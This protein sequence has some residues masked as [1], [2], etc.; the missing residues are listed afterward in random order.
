MRIK[1]HH[2]GWINDI[3]LNFKFLIIYVV[4]LLIPIFAINA[5]FFYRFAG[6][7]DE[8]EQ[9][10]YQI[11]LERARTDIESVLE[12]CIAVSHSISTDSVLYNLLDITYESKEAYFESYNTVLRNRVTTY[13]DVYDYISGLKLYVNNPT[14]SNGGSYYCI[15]DDIKHSAWYGAIQSSSQLVCVK[16]YI[17]YTNTFPKRQIPF[18]SV[19]QSTPAYKNRMK[20]IKV[21]VDLDRISRILKREA[22][23]LQLYLVDPEDNIVCASVDLYDFDFVQ[24]FVKLDSQHLGKDNLV[25]ETPVG[26]AGYLSGWRLVGQANTE[27]ISMAT[28]ETLRLILP[29]VGACVLISSLLILIIVRSYNYRL[30]KLSRHL[31]KLNNDR[32]DLIEIPEGKDEIGTVIQNFNLMAGKINN[33]INDVYKLELQ[34]KNLELERVRAELNYL[35]SQMNPH[36]LFN[37]LNALLVVSGK[38]NC[39]DVTDMLKYLSK[40]LRRLLNWKDDLVT[41]EEEIY[42]TEMYLKIEQFR[43]HE[44]LQYDI[45]VDPRLSGYRIPKMSLQP[46]AENASVHGIQMLKGTGRIEIDVC[47]RDGRLQVQ[48]KDNG[49]G[50]EKGKLEE[51]MRAVTSDEEISE[52][53]GIRNVYRRL[54]LYYGDEI[55]FDI[56]SALNEGTTVS[57][58]IPLDK[59]ESCMPKG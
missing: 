28:T 51:L 11:S 41:I 24:D 39:T 47:L 49:T 16:A 8:R 4:C 26:S 25:F 13:T 20:I 44:K 17:A 2:T 37:T 34:K 53:I 48:V 35:Q 40:T 43:F 57:F 45:H 56:A 12:G 29:L 6:V 50:I 14:I 52:N 9:N 10:N 15:D 22:E 31:L 30:K 3:P 59:L 1:H 19:L 33:L 5:V 21:D 27:R 54:R 32:F 55:S 42:F 38:Q 36:F 18:L 58:S 7:V 46:L 23:Y